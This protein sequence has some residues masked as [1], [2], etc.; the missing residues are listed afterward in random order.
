MPAGWHK[1]LFVTVYAVDRVRTVAYKDIFHRVRVLFVMRNGVIVSW[2]Q[3][4]VLY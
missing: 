1:K 4:S 3:D 2:R